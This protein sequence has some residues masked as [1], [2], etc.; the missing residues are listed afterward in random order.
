MMI[1][2]Q[3]GK[4]VLAEAATPHQ[5]CYCPVCGERVILKNGAI[6]VA[7]FAHR[8]GSNCACSE[9]ETA[10]HLLGKQ[11]LFA[12]AQRQQLNPRYEVYLPTIQQRPDIL[13]TCSDGRQIALEFQCSPLSVERLRQ[14]NTGYAQL[15]IQ[16]WWLLGMP[17]LKRSLTRAKYAQFMQMWHGQFG[18]LFWSTPLNRLIFKALPLKFELVPQFYQFRGSQALLIKQ[19][20]MLQH[21]VLTGQ[22]Q[23][24][25]L[26]TACYAQHRHVVGIPIVCH[27]QQQSFSLMR[28]PMTFWRVQIMLWLERQPLHRCWP[29]TSWYQLL[30]AQSN[31]WHELPCLA[32]VQVT[33]LQ[34]L[35]YRR[36][37]VDL[38]AAGILRTHGAQLELSARAQW[39]SHY[40]QKVEWLKHRHC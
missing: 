23:V 19:T 33:Q 37:T 14:R 17:Y 32:P 34:Q 30:A 16:V 25:A 27:W 31:C 28:T 4:R 36:Y 22:P 40:Q 24:K 21:H 10:E 11:Q 2:I 13:L 1:G 9:G 26:Q 38:V 18:V 8:H 15:K 3:N 6:K 7:H 20:G 5:P 29:V 39:F 12:W 35:V